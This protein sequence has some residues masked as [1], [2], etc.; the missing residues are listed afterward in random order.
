MWEGKLCKKQLGSGSKQRRV[1]PTKPIKQASLSRRDIFTNI[2]RKSFRKD[3][4][5]KLLCHPLETLEGKAQ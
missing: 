1:I 5:T 3:F 4:G 2:S